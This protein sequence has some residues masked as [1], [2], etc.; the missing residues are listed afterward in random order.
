MIDRESQDRNEATYRRL[1]SSIDQAYARDWFV[2]IA[3]DRVIAAAVQFHELE[4]MVRAQGKDPR[5]TLVVQAGVDSPQYVTI[6]I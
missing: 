1:K 6:F 5:S 2:A 4:M 3:D